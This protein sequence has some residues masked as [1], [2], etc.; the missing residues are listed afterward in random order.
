MNTSALRIG[1]AG[2]PD[3]AACHLEVLINAGY[4]ILG[5]YTQPDRPAGRGKQAKPS[6]V[7][8]LA[9][10]SNLLVFQPQSL[11][12]EEAQKQLQELN[13][14]V[15]VVVAY[16]LILPQAILDLPHFGCINVH[17]SLLPRW[18]GAAPIERALLAGDEKTG[19][20]I[21]QMDAGLDTGDM[22]LSKTTPIKVDDNSAS[23][24]AR[25]TSIGK[26]AL[27]DVLTQIQSGSL[28]PQT[29]DN[30]L[31][32]Y[33]SKLSK[34]EALISWNKNAKEIQ[35]QIN[36]FY[37]R[38]PAYCF[39][40]GQRLRIIQA[41]TQ[42]EALSIKTGTIVQ[43]NQGGIKVACNNSCLLIK[44]IQLPGKAEINI[45]DF[46]NGRRDY[47]S[48]GKIFSSTPALD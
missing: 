1:F 44:K 14:D 9:L 48:P 8:T 46:L 43:V 27:L 6:P 35:R 3:F 21:M 4:N 25:L 10:A 39:Y 40:N 19:I 33:A 47:F 42:N 12:S 16:G 32:T 23:L 2:T 22:L 37:P 15:L 34:E 36:A 18:R 7:K 30:K 24:T 5:V 20:T 28:S 45:K 13:L 38:S 17:A 26:D 29:Q 31:N 41:S 11:K